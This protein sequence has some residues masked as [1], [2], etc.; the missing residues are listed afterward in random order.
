MSKKFVVLRHG[1]MI[2]SLVHFIG[3]I[4]MILFVVSFIREDTVGMYAMLVCLMIVYLGLIFGFGR[5]IAL[6]LSRVRFSEQGIHFRGAFLPQNT[7]P[8]KLC[9]KVNIVF[10]EGGGVYDHYMLCFGTPDSQSWDGKGGIRYIPKDTS[11]I[12]SIAYSEFAW[13]IVEKH[14]PSEVL[15]KCFYERQKVI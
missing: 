14:L 2:F 12:I 7:I 11:K 6:T 4:L 9:T 5:L 3:S 10:I 1:G 8:W 15:A 13:S